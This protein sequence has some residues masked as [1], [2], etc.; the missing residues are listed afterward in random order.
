MFFRQ[1]LTLALVSL[2]ICVTRF[3]LPIE[4]QKCPGVNTRNIFQSNLR[5]TTQSSLNCPSVGIRYNLR[6]VL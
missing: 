5:I 2:M 3:L 1:L 4:M 6:A